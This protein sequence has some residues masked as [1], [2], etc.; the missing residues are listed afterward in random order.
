MTLQDLYEQHRLLLRLGSKLV[1]LSAVRPLPLEE[2]TLARREIA[3][4]VAHHLIHEARLALTPMRASPDPR[5]RALARHYTSDLLALRQA[6]SAHTA[7]WTPLAIAH[8]PREYRMAVRALLK[9]LAARIEWE[10][11]EFL[12]AAAR[13]ESPAAEL[14]QAG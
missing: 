9:S 14:R 13:L 5:D 6:S 3:Q 2:L 10:E 12:P 8:D 11:S 4:A 7:F 1:D